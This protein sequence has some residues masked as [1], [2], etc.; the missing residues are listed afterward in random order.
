MS[1]SKCLDPGN[2]R[3]LGE[4]VSAAI[5]K[6]FEIK[7]FW[8]HWVGPKSND[9]FTYKRQMRGGPCKDRGKLWGDVAT[10][11]GRLEHHKLEGA[12]KGF[13]QSRAPLDFRS[14]TSR[15]VRKSSVVLRYPVCGHWLRQAW[16][17][18]KPAFPSQGTQPY[19][20]PP[21]CSG[22]VCGQA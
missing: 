9:K 1:I 16:D 7:S 20:A 5:I 2:I 10:S 8:F 6:G 3:L 11:Q 19:L 18:S 21:T 22:P 17:A 15:T 4:R 12:G 14:V 13:L